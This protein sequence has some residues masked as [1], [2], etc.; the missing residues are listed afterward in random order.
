MLATGWVGSVMTANEPPP[1]DTMITRGCSAAWSSGR[2][3]CVTRTGP[4][5]FVS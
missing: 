3:A 4:Y 1:L 2:N 5:T